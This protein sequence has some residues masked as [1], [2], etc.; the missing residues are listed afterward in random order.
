MICDFTEAI[1]LG[2]VELPDWEYS[3]ISCEPEINEIITSSTTEANFYIQKTINYGEVII[4]W[5]LTLFTIV[6]IC[7]IIFNFLWKK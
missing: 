5:F 6:L 3:K 1:N 2:T 4:I 7:K